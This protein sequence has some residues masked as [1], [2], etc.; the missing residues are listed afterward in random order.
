M[1]DCDGLEWL[2]GVVTPAR[3]GS[4]V[5]RDDSRALEADGCRGRARGR[6]GGAIP[7]GRHPVGSIVVDGGACYVQIMSSDVPVFT[8]AVQPVREQ[9][10]AALL[11]TYIAYSGPCIIDDREG[12][13]TLKVEAAW[14]PD[15]VGT[16]QKRFFRFDGGRLLFGPN[17][18]P[19]RQSADLK[20]PG[21]DRLRRQRHTVIVQRTRQRH[22]DD[23]PLARNSTQLT[24]CMASRR[25]RPSSPGRVTTS[26]RNAWC[27]RQN[28][29]SPARSRL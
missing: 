7:V 2:G 26:G 16:E 15:Y 22:A 11:S 1:D 23:G 9:M 18:R 19:A 25:A 4:S 20:A 13:V 28:S 17:S 14:R 5:G 24:A 21:R 29:K 12:S 10:K 6:I 3:V 8:D 27:R